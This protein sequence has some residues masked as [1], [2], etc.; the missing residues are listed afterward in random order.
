MD[1]TEGVAFTA[2]AGFTAAAPDFM[3]A[4]LV[5]LAASAVFAVDTVSAAL[6]DEALGV[7]TVAIS[8]AAGST[9]DFA[10]MATH[11]FIPASALGSVSDGHIGVAIP[12]GVTPTGTDMT[13]HG[14][15]VRTLTTTHTAMTTIPTIILGMIQIGVTASTGMTGILETMTVA[16]TTGTSARLPRTI[17]RKATP[18]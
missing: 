12:I 1:F 15:P 17:N 9:E 5:A 6:E 18:L 14:A 3:V 16:V 4:G 11:A 10:A 8:M 2:E 7:S 13:R